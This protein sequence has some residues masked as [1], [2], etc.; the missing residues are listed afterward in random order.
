[1]PQ[2]MD[3]WSQCA[4]F[5]QMSETSSLETG[6]S[7]WKRI[8]GLDEVWVGASLSSRSLLFLRWFALAGQ[9]ITLHVACRMGL[10]FPIQR[11][12]IG[13]VVTAG[14]NVFLAWYVGRLGGQLREDF[15]HFVL[16]DLLHITFLLH[17][18]G[19]LANPFAVFYL[20]HL[21]LASL[22]L[23][24]SAV[25]GLG[26]IATGA[27]GWLWLHAI[28]LRMHDGSSP[29]DSL[30]IAGTLVALVTAGAFVITTLLAVRERSRRLL[31]ERERLQED[32]AERDRFLAV[33]ALVTGFAHELGTPI[34]TIRLA[35]E[36]LQHPAE[37]EIAERI[38]NEAIRCAKVLE[39]LRELGPEVDQ[40][41]GSE[42]EASELVEE[43]LAQLDETARIRIESYL[44]LGLKVRSAGLPEALLVLLRNALRV[45][46]DGKSVVLKLAQEAGE[47]VF[48][49]RDRGP[50]FSA[51]ILKHGGEPFRSSSRPGEGLGLGLFFVKRLAA[52]AGGGLGLEN[53]RVGGAVAI[54]RLPLLNPDKTTRR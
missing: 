3:N 35:S 30:V 14:S 23:K 2:R 44:E 29:P 33:S 10:D 46:P 20:V 24:T 27:C 38:R 36:E 39:R 6:G 48:T 47:A 8:F 26:L 42:R 53:A 22:T 34:G 12:L 49:I 40:L 28:P 17:W 16:W 19:G 7:L 4:T 32:L 5:P 15:F 21:V 11:C 9:A 41:A 37:A 13:L 52:A 51:E 1:M 54:L 31:Q 45:T 25:F 18:T 50:G 43:A